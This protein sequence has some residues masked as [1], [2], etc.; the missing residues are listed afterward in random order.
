MR[1]A[2][3]LAAKALKVSEEDLQVFCNAFSDHGI[4][5]G[6]K[7][8]DGVHDV[9]T[10]SPHVLPAYELTSGVDE[11]AAQIDGDVYAISHGDTVAWSQDS[12]AVG[13][14]ASHGSSPPRSV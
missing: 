3:V 11:R 1:H 12:A 2:V 14:R 7:Q 9:T 13:L 5:D 4:V 8:L 6:C 10:L